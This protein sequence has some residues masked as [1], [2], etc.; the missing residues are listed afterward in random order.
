[1]ACSQIVALFDSVILPIQIASIVTATVTVMTFCFLN[2]YRKKIW[3]SAA[4]LSA[5]VG[6]VLFFPLLVIT[7]EIVDR[8]RF[9]T[10]EFASPAEI[11][12]RFIRLPESARKI[13]LYK[14][15]ARHEARF[16]VE[17]SALT[18]WMA[19]IAE[20]RRD[21]FGRPTPF[22]EQEIA[23]PQVFESQFRRIGSKM[24]TDATWYR[25]WAAQNGAGLDVWYSPATREGFVAAW[26]W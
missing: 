13:V 21:E 16:T 4:G 23:S 18:D 25:G 8:V 6:V 20:R 7:W 15:S 1:M 3:S 2:V 22:R 14:N 11:H 10:F 17:R 5:I 12:D 24:P 26:Y 9:G 19:S